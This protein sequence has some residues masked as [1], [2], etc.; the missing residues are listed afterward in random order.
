MS[1]VD[2]FEGFGP[3]HYK[4]V[5]HV[6]VRLTS[7]TSERLPIIVAGASPIAG[8]APPAPARIWPRP[9]PRVASTRKHS[10]ALLARPV[11]MR[12]P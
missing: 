6:I 5:A 3:A 4:D 8:H 11:L 9:P 7:G 2:R 1:D 12:S 10:N